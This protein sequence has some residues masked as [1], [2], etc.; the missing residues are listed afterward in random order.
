LTL[1][2]LLPNQGVAVNSIAKLFV[3]VAVMIV[4]AGLLMG[5]GFYIV[6]IT[7]DYTDWYRVEESMC[8]NDDRKSCEE[9]DRLRAQNSNTQIRPPAISKPVNN[10]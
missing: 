5:P 8:M 9:L 10:P 1:V 7:G 4:L 6:A 3:L 2:A